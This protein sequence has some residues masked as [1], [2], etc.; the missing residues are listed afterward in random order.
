MTKTKTTLE[1]PKEVRDVSLVLSS[2][3]FENFMVG[4]C[5]RDLLLGRAPKDYDLTTIATP[6]EITPLFEHT[7]YEN[8]YGTVGIVNDE[9]KA[10]NLRVIEVTPY[11]TESGYSDFRRPDEVKWAKTLDEDLKRRDFTMNAVAYDIEKG[12]II[13]PFDGQ[14]DI[15][16]KLIRTVGDA[17]ERFKEDAL[18]MLRALRFAAELGFAIEEETLNAIVK[19][20]ELLKHI[21]KERIRDEFIKIVM[22][23]AP[24]VA[25]GL[26]TQLDI[27]EYISR[28][29]LKGIGMQQNQAHAFTVWEHLLRSLDHGAKKNFPLHV[30]L[31][32]LFHDIGKPDTRVWKNEQWTFYGHEVVGAKITKKVLAELN[33]SK[34]ISEKV[35]KLVRWHMFFSDT[36]TISL[37]AVRRMVRNVTPELIWDL[38]DVRACD[39]IGTG[40][41]KESPYR[42]RKYHAMIEEVMRD[43]I[44]VKHLKVNGADLMRITDMGP[45][46]HIGSIL[47]IL[48]SEVLEDPKKNTQA[49]LEDRVRALMTLPPA[50]LSKLGREALSKNK[51]EDEKEIE[52]IKGK[53]GVD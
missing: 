33:F 39:R 31:A 3:K 16:K 12:E 18:R 47:E 1:V 27:L 5:V 49:H 32:A 26:A 23:D 36:E 10:E 48:L 20:K 9:P 17:E 21:S 51:L 40:R 22:S 30:R 8:D 24:S 42:L 41:P 2:A 37:S 53:H 29:F 45:G 13:D 52:E 25:L 38:M 28:E 19:H 7:F 46:P 14:K 4:G 11:R 35:L 50:E 15:E 44:S 34:E 43:P 6:E